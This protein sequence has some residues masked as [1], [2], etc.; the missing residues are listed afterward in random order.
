[1]ICAY[2]VDL[3]GRTHRLHSFIFSPPRLSFLLLNPSIPGIAG[4]WHAGDNE[5]ELAGAIQSIAGLK[6]ISFRWNRGYQRTYSYGA[7]TRLPTTG[8]LLEIAKSARPSVTHY[9][10]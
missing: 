4:S 7:R 2:T 9:I 1:M 3:Y 5:S 10:S 6:R 8:L